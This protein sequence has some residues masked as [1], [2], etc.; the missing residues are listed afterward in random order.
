[1][2]TTQFACVFGS[3]LLLSACQVET[4]NQA[5]ETSPPETQ[6]V[7]AASVAQSATPLSA[8]S[9][10]QKPT[11]T[12]RAVADGISW[13][14]RGSSTGPKSGITFAA[15]AMNIGGEV[16]ICGVK[17]YYGTGSARFNSQVA[18]A[19]SFELNNETVLRNVAYFARASSEEAM[20]DTPT[21]CKATGIPWKASYANAPWELRYNGGK[22]YSF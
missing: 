16:A 7:K 22:Q 15:A 12:G 10:S 8:R 6:A 11:L 4:T 9:I 2:K 21:S 17:A 18:N 3:V 19:Y 1:M 5:A 20:P 14:G 13:R